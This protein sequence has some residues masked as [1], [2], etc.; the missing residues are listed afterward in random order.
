MAENMALTLEYEGLVEELSET[1][2]ANDAVSEAIYAKVGEMLAISF[3][4]G[5]K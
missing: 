3:V 5:T 1:S 2:K 4:S